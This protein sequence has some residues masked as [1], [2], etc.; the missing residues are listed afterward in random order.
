MSKRFTKIICA[1]LSAVVACGI[2]LFA[3]CTDG[4]TDAALKGDTS[5]NIESNGGFAV[6]KG[7]YIYFINGVESNSAN[8]DY[9]KPVR[10]AISR[11]SVADYRAHNYSKVDIVVPQIAYSANHDGGIFIYGDEIYY[12]TPSTT[13]NADGAVQYQNLEM[14]STKLDRSK[15]SAPYIR[16]SNASYQ[17]R[18]VEVEGTV[19]LLYVAT[20]ETLYGESSGV[21][22]IHSLNTKTGTNTL[23]AYNVASVMFDAENKSNERIYYTMNVKNYT[24]GSNY[25]NYNQVYTV[26]ADVTDANEYDTTDILGWDKDS[27]HYVN[28]GTLVFEGLGG[29]I[30]ERTPFNYQ[31]ENPDDP[32]DPAVNETDSYTYTLYN[33]VNGTLIFT[34]SNEYNPG[35]YLY[36]YKDGEIESSTPVK[37]N[38]EID[39]KH[40]LIDGTKAGNYKYLFDDNGDIEAVLYAENGGITINYV[41]EDEGGIKRLHK[42][43]DKGGNLKDSKYFNIVNDATA[44]LLFLDTDNKYLYY[45]ASGSVHGGTTV[46][47]YSVWR[48]SYDGEISDYETWKSE[49]DAYSPVQIL[50]L[51]SI[52]DWY[53]PEIIDDQLLYASASEDM[54]LYTY[55]MVCDLRKEDGSDLM[56]NAELR[57]LKKLYDSIE[58]EINTFDDMEKYP[59]DKYNKI[60]DVLRYGFYTADAEYVKEYIKEYKKNADNIVADGGNYVISE[61]TLAEYLG[62]IKPTAENKWSKY[63]EYSRTVNGEEVYA[64]SRNYYYSLLGK[65]N[66]SDTKDYKKW[67]ISQYFPSYTLETHTWWETL[68]TVE[69][70]FFVIGMCLI[71]L[72]VIAGATIL[73]LYLLK[74]N[75]KGEAVP[76]RRRIR[77]DTTDD[78]SIDVYNN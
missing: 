65:M 8:N 74:R 35:K 17:Y 62:F 72:I 13:K 78:K 42:E 76:K 2:L 71:G 44:T 9:G 34:R 48:V 47:G 59:I 27:D 30:V 36:T 16:F 73:V 33:Y 58:E 26:T 31:P 29:P 1:I 68:S 3:G 77:V 12:G 7:N 4:H 66:S 57:D 63:Y 45:S 55:I 41:Y 56:T 15:T 18:F 21:T 11:I 51:D 6:E 39:G 60:T 37:L 25:P 43:Q 23:L 10:G 50:N 38:K 40:L 70:V 64:T 5:G 67:F 32:D 22:N 61:E 75:K 19:Y 20:G 69:Q 49:P 54:T 52:T 24:S 46:N 14:Q 53:L 28:C